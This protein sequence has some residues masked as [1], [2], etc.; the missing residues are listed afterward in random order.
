M[1]RL[2]R[3]ERCV[4]VPLLCAGRGSCCAAALMM[5]SVYKR[6]YRVAMGR[7][8]DGDDDD[9]RGRGAG[10]LPPPPIYYLSSNEPLC[11]F[12]FL[13]SPL[14]PTTTLRLFSFLSSLRPCLPHTTPLSSFVE[15]L[16]FL[17]LSLSL[18]LA[19]P[20]AQPHTVHRHCT[21]RTSV[22]RE[23]HEAVDRDVCTS[24]DVH[25]YTHGTCA[26]LL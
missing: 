1:T 2:L 8:G 16:I 24:E 22:A 5:V 11:L 6:L 26:A 7:A 20:S 10:Q 15:H 13:S 3:S 21:P 9:H 23:T 25:I 4:G 19:T 18:R 14:P 12:S 17:S